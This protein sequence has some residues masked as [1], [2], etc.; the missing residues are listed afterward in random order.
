MDRTWEGLRGLGL[1]PGKG[2]CYK[3]GSEALVRGDR[4]VRTRVY[5]NSWGGRQFLFQNEKV[6]EVV[7]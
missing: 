3:C 7:P 2:K 5:T 6:D 1:V 4:W